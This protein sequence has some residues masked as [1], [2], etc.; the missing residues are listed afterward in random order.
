MGAL[1]VHGRSAGVWVLCWCMGAL[2]VH[3]RSAG[4]WVLC[5]CMGALLVHGRSAGARVLCAPGNKHMLRRGLTGRGHAGGHTHTHTHARTHVPRLAAREPRTA[6][7]RLLGTR[8]SACAAHPPVH[9]SREE[10]GPARHDAQDDLD[11][12]VAREPGEAQH[13]EGQA[14]G[15]VTPSQLP[16]WPMCCTGACGRD[17]AGSPVEDPLR[18]ECIGWVGMVWQR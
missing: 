13:R 6:H 5:W 17:S 16:M 10:V 8:A 11:H 1:L 7:R 18:S 2:L 4:A 9:A 3:G 14:R 12:K 15:E